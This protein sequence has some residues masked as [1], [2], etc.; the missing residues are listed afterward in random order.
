MGFKCGIVGLPN[1]GK[2]ILFNAMAMGRTR[3]DVKN[4]QFSTVQPTVGVVPV[5]DERVD[6]LT[7][8]SQLGKNNIYH[9]GVR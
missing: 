3:S 5:P 8:I 1:V 7:E 2:S 4:Y 6:K 9:Y